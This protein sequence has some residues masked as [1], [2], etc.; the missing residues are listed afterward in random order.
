MARF[1]YK[2]ITARGELVKGVAEHGTLADLVESLRTRQLTLYR[3]FAMPAWLQRA[4]S[5]R[6]GARHCAEFCHFLAEYLHAGADL[7]VALQDMSTNAPGLPV[8]AAARVLL[9]H[10]ER[11]NSFS[12][13]LRESRLFPSVLC[14]LSRVGEETGTLSVVLRA[15][16][17]QYEQT[18]KMRSTL[19]RALVYPIVA[20]ALLLAGAAFWIG[21]VLPKLALLFQTLM[22]TLPANTRAVLDAST[23]LRA[24]WV[25]LGGVV[26][27]LAAVFPVLLTSRA[28]Q[29]VTHWAR[30]HMPLIWRL[31]RARTFYL[32]F[33]SLGI[34]YSAGMTL[35]RAL[36]VL[37]ADAAN[38]YFARRIDV[39]ADHMRRGFSMSDS[40]RSTR[41]F[42]PIAIGM[43]RL[44]ES[45]G[46]LG[47]Q[48]EQLGDFYQV[49]LTSQ[50]DVVIRLFEP[51]VLLVLGGFLLL[52]VSTVILPIYD[53]AEAAS[54]SVRW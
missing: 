11:G 28:M 49:K 41:R 48:S 30:W 32:F 4:S 22:P 20:L 25:W 6:L 16:A 54:G 23:W 43:I 53:L 29:P 35:T 17:K 18:V 27:A 13:A 14:S 7:R 44:G 19:L 51:L 5:S 37:R 9:L 3:V 24:N 52:L 40:M 42:E 31:E 34:M 26:A 12:A 46:S 50:V 36:E 2:A 38:G 47:A 10:I 15:A 33:S 39:L 1:Y 45:T 8:R 21:Y